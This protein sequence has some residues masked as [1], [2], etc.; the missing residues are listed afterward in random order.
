MIS[1][2]MKPRASALAEYW[3][4]LKNSS[5]AREDAWELCQAAARYGGV[6]VRDGCF[7]FTDEEPWLAAVEAIRL[8]FGAEYF[9]AAPAR[10]ASG[11]AVDIVDSAI[12]RRRRLARCI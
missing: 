1:A 9:K 5:A 12:S 3:I 6:E 10:V 8:R 2:M 4:R 7:A 11:A